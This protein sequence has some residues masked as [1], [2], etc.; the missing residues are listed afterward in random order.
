MKPEEQE[1][2]NA[3]A[4]PE[5]ESKPSLVSLL[6]GDGEDD[7]DDMSDVSDSEDSEDIAELENEPAAEGSSSGS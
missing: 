1:G 3:A 5:S 4:K 6:R 2:S 7:E